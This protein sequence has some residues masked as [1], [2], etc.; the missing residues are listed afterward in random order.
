MEK[1]QEKIMTILEGTYPD[2]KI[3][4]FNLGKDNKKGYLIAEKSR[5]Q[6]L[7]E[8][9]SSI[10]ERRTDLMFVFEVWYFHEKLKIS[11][12]KISRAG[13]ISLQEVLDILEKYSKIFEFFECSLN[14]HSFCSGIFKVFKQKKVKG[15]E[16]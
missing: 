9:F 12:E 11:P 13:H 10:S 8:I 1:E 3:A 15:G 7:T 16:I 5:E 2:S 14:N 4:T 6:Y